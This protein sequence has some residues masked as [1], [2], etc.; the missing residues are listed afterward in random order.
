MAVMLVLQLLFPN[1]SRADSA[2]TWIEICSE[3][4]AVEIQVQLNDEDS[5]DKDCPDCDICLMCIAEYGQLRGDL[6]VSDPFA[7]ATGCGGNL[8]HSA[9]V[10]NP[11]QFWHDGRGPPRPATNNMKRACGASMTNTQSKEVASWT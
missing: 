9:E 6:V 10:S 2:T 1:L 7:V 8:H 3:F 11:A 5:Q 4:G